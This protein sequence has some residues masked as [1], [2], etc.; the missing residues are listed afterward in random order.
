MLF[1]FWGVDALTAL[2]VEQ[3]RPPISLLW[4]GRTGAFWLSRFQFHFFT[5]ILFGL[6]PALRSIRAWI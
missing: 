5:G 2:M 6:A 3:S 4:S 1:A